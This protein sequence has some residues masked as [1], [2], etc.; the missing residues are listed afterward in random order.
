MGSAAENIATALDL[1]AKGNEAFKAGNYK[2]AMVHYHQIFMYVHG[3]SEGS[4]SGQ[5][6]PGQTTQP[7]SA[8]LMGQIKELKLVHF[9]NLAMCHLKLGNVLKARDNSSKALAIAR[10]SGAH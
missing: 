1:K 8:E 3:F 9:S 7:V 10:G 2:E 5:S 4:G 6:M